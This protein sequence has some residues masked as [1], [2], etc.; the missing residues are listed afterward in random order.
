MPRVTPDDVKAILRKEPGSPLESFIETA[1]ALVTNLLTDL[2]SDIMLKQ[3]TLYLSAHFYHVTD[4]N[5]RE[6]AI[7]DSEHKYRSKVGMGLHLTHFGQ[8]AMVL[9]STGTLVEVN[10]TDKSR[11]FEFGFLGDDL[12]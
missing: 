6:Q 2:L 8:Q 5:Y 1:D 7:D 3:I 4:P 12:T 9:D 11:K 10:A